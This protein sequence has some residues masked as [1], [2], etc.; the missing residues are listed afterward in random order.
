MPPLYRAGNCPAREPA[1]AEITHGATTGSRQPR[2]LAA[3][4]HHQARRG[5]DRLAGRALA[6]PLREWAA[7][8]RRSAGRRTARRGCGRRSRSIC[9]AARA[10]LPQQEL[11]HRQGDFAFAGEDGVGAGLAQQRHFAQVG[12]PGEDADLRDSARGPGGSPPR[13]RACPTDVR[14]RP[15]A[16]S[17]PAAASVSLCVGVAIDGPQPVL[18][19][20]ADGVQ[21]QL[22]D[23]RL[24]VVFLQQP[25][26]R[27]ADGAV[28]DDD[29]PARRRSQAVSAISARARRCALGPASQRS[30]ARPA[31]GLPLEHSR[32]GGRAAG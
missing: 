32:S 25:H 11:G 31:L 20:P 4:I 27:A 16:C 29:G 14:N 30:R 1:G 8:A 5:L 6:R 28:A 15:S 7:A 21:V 10:E 18:A 13:C 2:Q 24:D 23:R 17:A 26:Q 3:L 22:D 19:Q 12:R 9:S